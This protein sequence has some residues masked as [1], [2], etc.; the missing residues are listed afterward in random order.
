MAGKPI[1]G[2]P[3]VLTWRNWKKEIVGDLDS[4]HSLGQVWD[5]LGRSMQLQA[6]K[7]HRNERG[8]LTCLL[9]FGYSAAQCPPRGLNQDAAN[10]VEG[11]VQDAGCPSVCTLS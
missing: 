6:L 2:E 4:M 8:D 7:Q 5:S 3:D 11:V 9:C 1:R 10:M